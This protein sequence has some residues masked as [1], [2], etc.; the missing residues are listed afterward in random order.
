M[1]EEPLKIAE[2]I[3]DAIEESRLPEQYRLIVFR[4]ILEHRLGIRTAIPAQA[5]TPEP[6]LTAEELSFSEFLNQF[7]EQLRTNPQRF[8]AVASYYERYRR[9]SSVTQEEIIGTMTDAGL[10]PPA[11]FSRDIRVA[12]STRSALLMPSRE[13]KN[14]Q[15]AWQLTRTGRQFIEKQLSSQA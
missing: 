3:A 7:G 1:Q 2:E 13:P 6:S 10:R 5:K 12:T 11:N 8:A 4:A 14:G 9:E 15:T